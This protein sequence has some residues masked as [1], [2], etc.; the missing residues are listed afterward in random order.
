LVL[1]S[2]LRIDPALGGLRALIRI[3]I[4]RL[5]PIASIDG[6]R[7]DCYEVGCEYEVGNCVGA[8][9]LA[10]EWAE[11]VPLDAPKPPTPFTVDD[12]FDS[13]RLYGDANQPVNLIRENSPPYLDR[14]IAADFRFHRRPSGQ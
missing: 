13:H 11:P 1:A 9:L 6:I 5:P 4:I 12:P 7:L 10:E 2:I 14:A 8:L 3:R